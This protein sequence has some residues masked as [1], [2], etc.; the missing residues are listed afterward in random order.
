MESHNPFRIR[1]PGLSV[2]RAEIAIVQASLRVSSGPTCPD[3]QEL[4]LA[5][6]LF[7]VKIGVTPELRNWRAISKGRLAM[8]IVR[9]RASDRRS[10]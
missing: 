9:R 3:S 2:Y 10:A 6:I 1:E 5:R 4:C 8:R 7:A